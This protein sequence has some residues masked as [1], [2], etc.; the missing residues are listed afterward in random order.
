[1]RA[2]ASDPDDARAA[3]RELQSG[4]GSA[5]ES[6]RRPKCARASERR[7][8]RRSADAA[9]ARVA[10]RSGSLAVRAR[11]S[12]ARRE[13]RVVGWWARE[14]A[15]SDA[16]CA[17]KACGVE[18]GAAAGGECGGWGPPEMARAAA[19]RGRRRKR[20][21]ED[22]GAMAAAGEGSRGMARTARG[23]AAM[24]WRSANL[25]SCTYSS[26]CACAG[27]DNTVRQ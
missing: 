7:P 21:A 10:G 3:S 12:A 11:E 5:A 22:G 23:W 18:V 17:W 25:Y 14:G 15:A 6:G 27:C 9:R 4:A 8:W 19:R 20:E 24:L 1:M 2:G 16:R 26:S 13:G